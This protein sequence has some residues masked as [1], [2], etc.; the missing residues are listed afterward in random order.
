MRIVR[1][2]V[3]EQQRVRL[4]E[5]NAAVSVTFTFALTA[6]IHRSCHARMKHA[7]AGS[8]EWQQRQVE[9]GAHA[10]ARAQ[11]GEKRRRVET[12]MRRVCAVRTTFGGNL[13]RKL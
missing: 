6:T 5:S 12:P 9:F 13:W 7:V 2:H 8:V 10:F 11:F 1:I 4:R 3:A